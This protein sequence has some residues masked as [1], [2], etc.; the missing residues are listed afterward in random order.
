MKQHF[1]KNIYRPK[2]ENSPP[3]SK[4]NIFI[5]VLFYYRIL[6]HYQ[7]SINY[8]QH[9]NVKGILNLLRPSVQMNCLPHLGSQRIPLFAAVRSGR[10]STGTLQET[11]LQTR[12]CKRCQLIKNPCKRKLYNV[13]K[14]NKLG[15]ADSRIKV[16]QEDN[17]MVSHF[18]SWKQTTNQ[19]ERLL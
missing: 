3:V 13:Q 6:N 18:Q 11:C 2:Q 19:G 12:L 7:L 17:F 5:H 4:L 1:R 8:S 16:L 9:N 14:A 10:T 15:A